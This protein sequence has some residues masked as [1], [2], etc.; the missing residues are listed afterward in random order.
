[1]KSAL[2]FCLGCWPFLAQ[3]QNYTSYFTGNTTDVAPV[4][5]GGIC[6]MGGSTED[7][8]A[9]KWFLQRANGGDVLVLRA[10]GADGYNDYFYSDLGVS[11]NSVE[12]IVCNNAQASNEAYVLQKIQQAEAV[13]LAGGN[14]WNYVSYWRNTPVDSLLNRAIQERNIVIGGTSAGMAVQGKFYFSAQN[15]SVTSGAALANPYLP[16]VTVDSTTFLKNTHLQQVI[17]DTH[18]DNPNRKGRL[19]VFLARIFTD[20]GI[21]GKA[22]ACDEYTAVCIEP[23]GQ[24]RVFG[25][26]PA[27]DDNAYFVQINCTLSDPAPETCAPATP[28][29]WFA[30]GQALKVCR[31][32]GTASG[33]NTFNLNDWKSNVNGEWFDWSVQNGVFSEQNGDA[34]NCLPLSSGPGPNHS[35][36]VVY[37][38]PS[39]DQ[40]FISDADGTLLDCQFRLC[41]ALG[42]QL[43][44]ELSFVSAQQATLSLRQYP[45]GMYFL[46]ISKG[47]TRHFTQTIFKKAD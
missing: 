23:N 18:F 45:G 22:I 35:S 5:Q 15:G 26:Y 3:T 32:R 34:P 46:Q 20:F 14:Q 12:T 43:L 33:N 25:G 30:N 2:L 44:P 6:L 11:V 38:N 27:F 19:T 1:M 4:P 10:S 29:Q 40:L 36:I 9:M 28:L 41:N 8:N 37:P 31:V 24:A 13:W 47:N 7:D 42:Q 17:T 39:A 16:T 21:S